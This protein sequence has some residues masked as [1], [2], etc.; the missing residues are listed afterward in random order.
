MVS[1]DVCAPGLFLCSKFIICN[2]NIRAFT[3][4]ANTTVFANTTPE[5]IAKVRFAGSRHSPFF[6]I[7]TT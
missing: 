1:P 7:N 6:P 3:K 5:E 4:K 2:T